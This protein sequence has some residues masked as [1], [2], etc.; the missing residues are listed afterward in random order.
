VVV[1]GENP[2]AELRAVAALAV[3]AGAD[4]RS[5]AVSP[6]GD[7]GF[8]MP[9]TEFPDDSP[10][11]DLYAAARKAFPGR[12]VGGGTFV[13]FTELNRKPPPGDAIDFVIHGTCAIVHAADDRSVTE[14]IECLP[15]V[16]GSVRAMFGDKRYRA[17][18]GSIG[19]RPAPFGGPTSPNPQSRRIAMTRADPRQRG[20]LGAAWHLGYAA[21]MAAGGADEVVLGA[22][23]GEFGLLHHPQGYPQPWYDEHGGLY[24][25]Y[26]VMRG[27]YAASGAPRRATEISAP[28]EVQALAYEAGGRLTVWLANLTGEPR[29]VVLQGAGGGARVAR[30]AASGFAALA[31]D[32]DALSGPGEPAGGNPIALGPYEVARLTY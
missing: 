9:G 25:A 20:L 21:Q 32:R 12:P 7:L 31:A 19:S 10:F 27:V 3:E 5:V 29:T 13:Y 14:T 22:P 30:I 23:V 17:G 2:E 24:P 28:R 18:P 16:T 15:Y 26:H 8:V 11:R 4:F 6:A 1:A